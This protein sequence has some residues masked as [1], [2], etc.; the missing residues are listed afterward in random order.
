[1]LIWFDTRENRADLAPGIDDERCAFNPHIF[2]AVHTL[3]LKHVK[4]LG[5]VLVH[6]G[7]KGIGQV[8]LFLEFLLG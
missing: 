2:L 6:V 3:F 1:M 5:Q 4:F 7:K 8:V